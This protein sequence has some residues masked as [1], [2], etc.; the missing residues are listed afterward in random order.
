MMFEDGPASAMGRLTD[1]GTRPVRVYSIDD[2]VANGAAP[3]HVIKC[4]IEGAEFEALQ[5]AINTLRTHHPTIFLSFHE[6][7]IQ[8][9]CCTLLAD[10]GYQLIPQDGC[11]LDETSE[12][13]A[14]V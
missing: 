10:L 11:P 4:D 12:I 5:G 9:N 3:P 6:R 2:L 8:Q 1:Q 7:Q 13:I 14:T